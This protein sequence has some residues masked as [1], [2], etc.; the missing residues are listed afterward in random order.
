MKPI[1]FLDYWEGNMMHLAPNPPLDLSSFD[2]TMK[3]IVT[4][5][6]IEIKNYRP[7]HS[8]TENAPSF[9]VCQVCQAK[10]KEGESKP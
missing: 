1:R 5:C 7:P 8:L 4:L 9:E 10:S 2:K 6:G 3:P